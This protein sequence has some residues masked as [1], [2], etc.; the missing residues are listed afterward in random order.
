MFEHMDI[1][2]CPNATDWMTGAVTGTAV[3]RSERMIGSLVGLFA[4][5]ASR[6]ALPQDRLAYTTECIFPVPEGTAGGLFWGTTWI[7]PLLVGEEYLMTKGHF[8]VRSDRTE[9]Y[10][11]YAG[12]GVLLLMD[13][14][15]RCRAERM[16]PGST[17]AIPPDTAHRTVNVG[18]GVLSFG[19][20][21][22]SDA[23]HDY[24]TIAREGFSVRVMRRNGSPVLVPA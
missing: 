18:T 13:R 5:E 20:C 22:P 14:E 21:W 7:E 10:F 12:E 11:T 24:T 17:H 6:A 9:F 16:V 19:A 2:T 8:H 4:D 15:R 23:G 3:T 1:S